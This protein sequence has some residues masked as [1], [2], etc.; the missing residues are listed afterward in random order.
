M[1]L[2][3]SQGDPRIVEEEEWKEDMLQILYSYIKF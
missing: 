1:Q 2:R 3:E